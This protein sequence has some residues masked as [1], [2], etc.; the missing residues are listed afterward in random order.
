MAGVEAFLSDLEVHLAG[1][2]PCLPHSVKAK[3]ATSNAKKRSSSSTGGA[4]AAAALPAPAQ[5][6]LMSLSAAA[7]NTGTREDGTSAAPPKQPAAKQR[8][9]ARPPLAVNPVMLVLNEAQACHGVP[10][11]PVLRLFSAALRAALRR[12]TPCA[13]GSEAR[14][15]WQPRQT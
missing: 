14:A 1:W 2:S 7:A 9:R 3:S 12:A 11:S 5:G 8:R 6:A 15:T 10:R 4:T 13:P